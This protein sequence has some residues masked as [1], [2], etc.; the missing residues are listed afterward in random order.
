VLDTDKDNL[1]SFKEVMLGFHHLSQSGNEK[2]KM[3]IVFQART[4][5]TT[6][7]QCNGPLG[8]LFLLAQYVACG[9]RYTNHEK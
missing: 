6:P 8:E 2:E 3:H 7:L 1:V 5:F 4:P 9:R